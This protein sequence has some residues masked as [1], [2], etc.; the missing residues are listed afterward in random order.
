MGFFSIGDR[1]LGRLADSGYKKRMEEPLPCW[2]AQRRK[3][4]EGGGCRLGGFTRSGS[5]RAGEMKRRRDGRS[6]KT[7]GAL[8]RDWR[9]LVA[10]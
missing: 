10:V 4:L 1:A 8:V 5:T 9:Y 3:F 6:A 2:G 7:I